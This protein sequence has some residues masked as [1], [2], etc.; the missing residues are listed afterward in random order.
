MVDSLLRN[1]EISIFTNII[2]INMQQKLLSA[3]KLSLSAFMDDSSRLELGNLLNAHIFVYSTLEDI[4]I[5]NPI[6][7][8]EGFRRQYKLQ[9]ADSGYVSGQET[10][11]FADVVISTKSSGIEVST[12]IKAIDVETGRILLTRRFSEEVNDSVKWAHYSGDSRALTWEDKELLNVSNKD[13]RSAAELAEEG[14]TIIGR[15]MSD[16]LHSILIF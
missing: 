5:K 7:E 9:A 8:K 16:A 6:T 1:P 10:Y 13:V 2:D 12:T 14:S 4:R 3:Q 15:S 11:V